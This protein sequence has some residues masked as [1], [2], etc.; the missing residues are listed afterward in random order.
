MLKTNPFNVST[1]QISCFS[2]GSVNGDEK[3]INDQEGANHAEEIS[4][5]TAMQ[6]RPNLRRNLMKRLHYF[7]DT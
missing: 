6:T 3:S 4:F 7:F 5:T 1:R 2:I